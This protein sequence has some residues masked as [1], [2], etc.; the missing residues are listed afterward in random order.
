[1][2]NLKKVALGLV[3]MLMA[4]GFSAFTNET[5]ERYVYKNTSDLNINDVSSWELESN[6][7]TPTCENSFELPCVIEISEPLEDFLQNHNTASSIM[8]S[9]AIVST[10]DSE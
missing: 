9:Y 7:P 2:N 10:K 6:L 4:F 1:M 3:V 8:G 5:T